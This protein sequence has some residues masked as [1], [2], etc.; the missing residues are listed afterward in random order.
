MI[1]AVRALGL[2]QVDDD[3]AVVGEVGGVLVVAEAR[4]VAGQDP[5]QPERAVVRRQQQE[6]RLLRLA[7]LAHLALEDIDVDV[8]R[9]EHDVAEL[10]AEVA[11]AA[12]GQLAQRLHGHPG[13]HGMRDDVDAAGA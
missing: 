5:R 11:V 12:D 4:L 3:D 6:E 2:R 9:G 1:E 7:I 8:G 10:A 13:A